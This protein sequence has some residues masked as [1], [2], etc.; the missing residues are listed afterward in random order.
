MTRGPV[1]WTQVHPKKP[2]S[3]LLS[4]YLREKPPV[5][6]MWV[7]GPVLSLSQVTVQAAGTYYCL[8][9]NLTTEIHMKVT[10]RQ[11]IVGLH[12][13]ASVWGYWKNWEPIW[14]Q[15]LRVGSSLTS[16]PNFY[17]EQ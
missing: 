10:A 11:G 7:L 1:S 12:C 13:G 2:D 4:L 17:T 8:R 15:N 5:Q 3:T 16:K 6:E 9:G 14:D